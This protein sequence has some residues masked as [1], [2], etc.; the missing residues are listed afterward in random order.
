[1]SDD[2]K[3]VETSRA[4]SDMEN[5]VYAVIDD[6]GE[7]YQHY[8]VVEPGHYGLTLRATDIMEPTALT[9]LKRRASVERFRPT[10]RHELALSPSRHS[11]TAHRQR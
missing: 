5:S 11:T 10:E 6:L 1:M 9:I 2:S 8:Y 4:W 7:L 3:D